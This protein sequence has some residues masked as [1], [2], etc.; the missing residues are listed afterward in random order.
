MA[1]GGALNVPSTRS[2]FVNYSMKP[3]IL[4]VREERKFRRFAHQLFQENFE[5]MLSE[6]AQ[7]QTSALQPRG[8]GC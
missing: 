1:A 6:L 5:E 7:N 3:I 2:Y 8:S 4:N